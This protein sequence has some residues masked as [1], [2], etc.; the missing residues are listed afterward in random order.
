MPTHVCLVS[1]NVPSANPRLVKDAQAL[2]AAGYK[3]TVVCGLYKVWS[4]GF[5]P[6]EALNGCEMKTVPFGP[7]APIDVRIK[8][9]T[10]RT[11]SRRLF[12]T[13]PKSERLAFWACGDCSL[14]LYK[15]AAAVEADLYIAH[16]T[17]ALPAVARAAKRRS[18][19]YAFDAEDFHL[20]GTPDVPEHNIE[21]QLIRTIEEH[22]LAGASYVTAASPLIAEAY[23]ETY[24]IPFP[25]VILN[26]F[27]KERAPIAPTPRGVA[28]PGPSIYWFSQTIGPGRGLETAIDAIA[29]TR[30]RPHL[31]LRGTSTSDYLKHL[32]QRA[33]VVGVAD[34][35]RL[36]DP[37]PP[38]ELERLGAIYD[39]GF[40][41]EMGFSKNNMLAL[42]NKLFSYLLGGVPCIASDIPAHRWL[43][44]QF[45][46]AM[47]LFPRDDSSALAACIDQF[48]LTP[49][50][51]ASARTY[52]WNLGQ[53][54]FNWAIEQQKLLAVVSAVRS[55]KSHSD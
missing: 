9:V 14:G 31:Y 6:P 37:A 32:K 44:P 5:K 3:V 53:Q 35:L 23:A 28:H 7:G 12:A 41:G 24:R 46:E 50:R 47:T 13:S 16:L 22:H 55:P 36:L 39:L 45:G 30:S 38:D 26:V 10:R 1:R 19:P 51:L 34:R 15:S 27:P 52:A 11:L 4:Q 42:G 18:V 21:K 48:L 43:A 25:T 29:K 20:G 33:L 49:D 40:S 54:R 17:E 2:A 8:Q